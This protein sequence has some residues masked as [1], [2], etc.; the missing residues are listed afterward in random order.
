VTLNVASDYT[1]GSTTTTINEDSP[2][3][4]TED[5]TFLYGR[6]HATRQRIVGSEGNVS[7]YY[8]VYCFGPGCD[9]SLLP[10]SDA[11]TTDDPRW[12]INT[13][14]T[15][16]FGSVGSIN[17]KGYAVNTGPV[18]SQAATNTNPA[19]A[20]LTYHNDSYPYKTT[21][22]NNASNWLIYAPYDAG[23]TKNEFDVE[24]INP[25]SQWAGQHETNTS[26]KRN[27]ANKT[28]RRTM[29]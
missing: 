8:E 10:N 11:N 5:A 18:T 20:K 9:K 17:Q 26:T 22:E 4:A 1:I 27:A 24:F 3:Q 6:T 16:S 15:S 7:L 13:Q 23:A 14:H 25:S 2:T 28:N 21:M 29:W 19:K 12:Y